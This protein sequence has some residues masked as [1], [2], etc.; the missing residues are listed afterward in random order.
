MLT[1]LIGLLVSLIVLGLI[2]ACL[3]WV[4]TIILPAVP[5]LFQLAL[6]VI[7]SLICLIAVLGLLFGGWA[8]PFAGHP[9]LR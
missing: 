3:W 5:P 2:L 4:V 9:V 1:G 6:R 8:F 7:F